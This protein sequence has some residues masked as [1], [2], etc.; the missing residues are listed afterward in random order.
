MVAMV[1]TLQHVAGQPEA[2]ANPD[3]S[4]AQFTATAC[5]SRGLQTTFWASGG[6]P[7][8]PCNLWF[9]PAAAATCS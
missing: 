8:L 1:L 3:L 5:N 7:G 4:K 6:L 9:K 2:Q